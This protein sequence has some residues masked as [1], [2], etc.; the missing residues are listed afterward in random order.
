MRV[1]FLSLVLLAASLAPG[2]SSAETRYVYSPN[3]GYL[4]LRT[5]PG[6]D[7]RIIREMENYENVR[8]LEWVGRWVRVEHES[9]DR[10][11]ASA[12]YLKRHRNTGPR[13]ALREVYSPGDG[14]LNL[15]SGPGTRYRIIMEMYNGET[16]RILRRRGSWVRI[17]HENGTEGWASAKYL[18][19]R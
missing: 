12:R 15:R 6:T 16:V 19:R 7:Y 5:G 13:G 14:Y 1:L 2:T 17:R 10:G 8:I 11:W 18:R 9:G 4:N 3:D